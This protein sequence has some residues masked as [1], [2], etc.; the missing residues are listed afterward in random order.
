MIPRAMVSTRG[1]S[2]RSITGARVPSASGLWRFKTKDAILVSCTFFP[3]SIRSR[4]PHFTFLLEKLSLVIE[5][6]SSRWWKGRLSVYHRLTH[7]LINERWTMNGLWRFPFRVNRSCGR[8]GCSL[9]LTG[10]KSSAPTSSWSH[11]RF[12]VAHVCR[13][14]IMKTTV[15]RCV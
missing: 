9:K 11:C 13:S 12:L 4:G 6:F 2:C 14:L 15:V 7:S 3:L 10:I 8:G 1:P 5:Y